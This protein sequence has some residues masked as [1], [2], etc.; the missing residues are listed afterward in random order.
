[1]SVGS[2]FRIP[3]KPSQKS[4]HIII[5]HIDE[6]LDILGEQ[7]SNEGEEEEEAAESKLIYMIHKKRTTL[8]QSYGN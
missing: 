1:M 2:N 8:K 4:N 7:A 3:D 6:M 5:E